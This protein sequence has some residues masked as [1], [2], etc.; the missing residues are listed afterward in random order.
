WKFTWESQSHASVIRL[1]LFNSDVGL[2]SVVRDLEVILLLEESVLLVSFMENG[3]EKVTQLRVQIPRVLIDPDSP[4]HF[5]AFD[6]HIE[7]K[8][9]LLLPVDHPLVSQVDS[10]LNLEIDRFRPTADSDLKRLSCIEE[11]HF[12]C[13]HCSSKLTNGLRCFYEMPSANWRDV[14]DNWFGNC[15]CSFGGASEK[16]VASYAKSHVFAPGVGF[17]SAS[18]LLLCKSDL[19]GCKLRDV[20]VKPKKDSKELSCSRKISKDGDCLNRVD[21]ESVSGT[22]S[23]EVI[24]GSEDPLNGERDSECC[25]N[26]HCDFETVEALSNLQITGADDEKILENERVFLDGYLGDGFMLKSSAVSNEIQ[27]SEYLCSQCSSLIGAYP[28]IDDNTPLDGGVRL[29]KYNIS[30]CVPY[31]ESEDVF[32]DYSLE[33]AFAS[34]L[35]ESAEDELSYRTIVRDLKTKSSFLYIVLLNPNLRG[36]FG[37]LGAVG[38]HPK[39]VLN[40]VIKVLY[41]ENDTELVWLL[42]KDGIDEIYML[43]SPTRELVKFLNQSNFMY[44]SSY[45]SLQGMLLSSM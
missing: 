16:L 22:L 11:V 27:W 9:V 26:L 20:K 41:A 3:T 14:A 37:N 30:T 21:A 39:L 13:R 24:C 35:L 44:P 15:C 4:P 33:R 42:G 7:V 31:G 6:D 19:L 12:Y 25:N 5:N 36:C 29:F 23:T 40:P 43:S 38:T 28:C 10:I 8:L 34:Q 45:A 18:S 17:L 2:H 32:R 1:L